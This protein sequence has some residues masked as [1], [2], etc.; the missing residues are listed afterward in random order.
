MIP[1]NYSLLTMSELWDLM[2]PKVH[3]K[4]F[5]KPE[6]PTRRWGKITTKTSSSDID[7][8]NKGCKLLRDSGNKVIKRIDITNTK[9]FKVKLYNIYYKNYERLKSN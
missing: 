1:E 3:D 9:K 4:V 5:I 8:I 2:N 6:F 7:A